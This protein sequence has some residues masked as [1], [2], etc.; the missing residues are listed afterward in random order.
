MIVDVPMK[1]GM[2]RDRPFASGSRPGRMQ[3]WREIFDYKEDL[4]EDFPT[5]EHDE[6]WTVL[7]FKPINL[8]QYI[9]TRGAYSMFE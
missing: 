8:P 6:L 2:S 1:S 9:F 5:A 3:L 7:F 4:M